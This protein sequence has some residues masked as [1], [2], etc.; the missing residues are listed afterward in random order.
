[1]GLGVGIGRKVRL[2]KDTLDTI[3]RDFGQGHP[4]RRGPVIRVLQ[5][6]I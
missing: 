5:S 4:T 2:V 6:T 3:E 1:M